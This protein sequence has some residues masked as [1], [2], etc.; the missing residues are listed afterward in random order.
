MNNVKIKHFGVMDSTFFLEG[1]GVKK[2]TC[3]QTCAVTKHKQMCLTNQS[4]SH[5]GY[6][7][8]YFPSLLYLGTLDS[9]VTFSQHE[10]KFLFIC[11]N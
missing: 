5:I 4:L 3:N 2:K 10:T 11:V 9:E 6:D 7:V 1:G 8:V